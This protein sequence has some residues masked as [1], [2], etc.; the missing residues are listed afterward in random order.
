MS[1]LVHALVAAVAIAVVARHIGPMPHQAPTP[2]PIL[3]VTPKPVK[4]SPLPSVRGNL[5][6]PAK[7]TPT[8]QPSPTPTP[9]PK[10]SPS[11]V[12]KPTPKPTPKP[13]LSKEQEQFRI[14]RQIPYF[15]HMTDAQLRR[16]KLPPGLKQWS[17]VAKMDKKLDALPWLAI[18][19]PTGQETPTPATNAAVPSAVPSPLESVLNGQHTLSFSAQGTEFVATWNDGDK[20]VNVSAGVAVATSTVS[21]APSPAATFTVPYTPQRDQLLQAILAAYLQQLFGATGTAS[22]LPSP[23]P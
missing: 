12:S 22:P 4:P 16:Q 15:K 7:P 19:P 18:A 6:V 5:P 13:K 9:T 17:D 14:M 1:L 21:P 10:P 3:V 8:P 2:V 11:P 23:S 20:L